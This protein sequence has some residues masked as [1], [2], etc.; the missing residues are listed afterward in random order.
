MNA[1][2][3]IKTPAIWPHIPIAYQMI[4]YLLLIGSLVLLYQPNKRLKNLTT[5]SAVTGF[6]ELIYLGLRFEG[7]SALTWPI[8]WLL[9]ALVLLAWF[10]LI[11]R[12]L[13]AEIRTKRTTDEHML[14]VRQFR[15][16]LPKSTKPKRSSK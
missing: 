8:W 4:G 10:I 9:T 2:L 6:L 12:P 13:S 15:Q 16:Y 5:W 7:V 1:Q 3:L 11:I 14:A